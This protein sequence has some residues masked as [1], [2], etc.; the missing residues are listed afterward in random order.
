MIS[1]GLMRLLGTVIGML[2]IRH[3]RPMTATRFKER[4]R[5]VR[6]GGYGA[7]KMVRS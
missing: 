6:G 3:N 7:E 4:A 1:D 5:M 2:S